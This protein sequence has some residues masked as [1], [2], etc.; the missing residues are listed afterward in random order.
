MEIMALVMQRLDRQT[1]FRDT[2]SIW[3]F[4]FVWF[5]LAVLESHTIDVFSAGDHAHHC[6]VTANFHLCYN[7]GKK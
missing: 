5:Q 4:Q 7:S 3:V 2:V 1:E 6:V